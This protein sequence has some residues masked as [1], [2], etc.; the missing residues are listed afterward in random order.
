MSTG[1]VKWF[2]ADKGFGFITSDEGNDIFVHYTEI[3]GNGFRTL[4]EGAKVSFDIKT[5]DRGDHAANVNV[6]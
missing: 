6:L 4:E 3:Q 1:K 2:N 5:N